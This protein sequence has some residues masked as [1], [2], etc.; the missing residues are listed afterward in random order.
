MERNSGK[1][2][3]ARYIK[4]RHGHLQQSTE[5]KYKFIGEKRSEFSVKKMCQVRDVSQSGYYRWLRKPISKR[6]TEKQYLQRIIKDLFAK[7]KGMA[8]SPMI[9]ADL[10]DFP[11]YAKVSRQQIS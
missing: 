8:G 9:A 4:K 3:G 10:R 1:R 6:K 7:H 5:M 2:D 11:E